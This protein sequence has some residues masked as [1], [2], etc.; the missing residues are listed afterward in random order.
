MAHPF[1]FR[2]LL[3]WFLGAISAHAQESGVP[4]LRYEDIP[5][6]IREKNEAVRGT[7]AA[8]SGA[9]LRTG[10]LGRSYFPQ[11]N[12]SGG[13]ERFQ[14]GDFN[15]S[16]QP[17]GGIEATVNLYRGGKD[18]LEEEIRVSQAR[19]HQALA[20]ATYQ[21]ELSNAQVLYW[22]MVYSRELIAILTDAF[23]LNEQGLQSAERRFRRGLVTR[24]DIAE[25]EI[26][27]GRIREEIESLEHEN[28]LTSI[29]LRSLLGFEDSGLVRVAEERIGHEH[30]EALVKKSFDGRSNPDLI[31]FQEQLAITD[32]QRAKASRWWLPTLEVYGG[33][34]LNP[35]RER[36][37]EI[38]RDRTDLVAGVRLQ[39]S[40]FD[41]L[42]A[43]NE[44]RALAVQTFALEKQ[45]EQ[46]G[47]S[48]RAQIKTTQG[49]MTHL[50]ELLHNSEERIRL[51]KT[52]LNST[53]EEYDR[54]V[55]NSPDLLSAIER[56]VS[57]EEQYVQ[58]RRDYQRAK[59][60][61]TSLV[62]EEPQP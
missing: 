17:Y 3:A 58:R 35:L 47:R 37:F 27:R 48:I 46:R 57:Y 26:Y 20:Q 43:E 14:R 56:W 8:V 30:D 32:L 40:L 4:V 24:T 9:K 52:Y 10:Y 55:K 31:Y 39:F 1:A 29:Q 2:I 15:P 36:A 33:Y 11:V 41:G 44:A 61:L 12:L 60:R 59:I 50:H 21:K 25:F 62:A 13:S 5:R 54:G 18:S 53:L 42:Q 16:P 34:F 49:E 23:K 28:E 38:T 51:G 19:S 22:D 7:E 6:F 45:N